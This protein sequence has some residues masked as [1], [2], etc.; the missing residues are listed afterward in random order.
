MNWILILFVVY[1]VS[2]AL[3]T[4]EFSTR[5]ICHKSGKAFCDSRKYGLQECDFV[6]LPKG[7]I[8]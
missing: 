5:E 1:N 6:C 8:K 4:A 3:T 2:P 7:T